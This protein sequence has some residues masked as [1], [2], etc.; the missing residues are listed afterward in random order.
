MHYLIL[1][2]YFVGR[3]FYCVS[4]SSRNRSACSVSAWKRCEK[5][6]RKLWNVW[7]LQ[8]IPGKVL[9]LLDTWF[10]IFFHTNWIHFVSVDSTF[11][12]CWSL[13]FLL[14]CCQRSP[15]CRVTFFFYNIMKFDWFYSQISWLW[16]VGS[17]S[18][19][20][21]VLQGEVV[22]QCLQLICSR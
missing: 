13:K 17:V 5:H 9:F 8:N 20:L 12:Y 10:L 6:Q 7:I 14:R 11:C 21:Q 4:R 18:V 15:L 16:Y 2:F 3:K 22:K 19:V 1:C